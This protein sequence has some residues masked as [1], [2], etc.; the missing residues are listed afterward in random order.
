V[1]GPKGRE[2]AGSATLAR[3]LTMSSLL[4][5]IVNIKVYRYR[6]NP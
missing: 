6:R 4:H 5:N 1:T 2:R 3:I